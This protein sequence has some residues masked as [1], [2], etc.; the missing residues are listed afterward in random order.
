MEDIGSVHFRLQ[1]PE[2]RPI[3]YLLRADVKLQGS[4]IF[5]LLSE[6]SEGWPFT[7]EN[8]SDYSFT[9]YQTVRLP[10]LAQCVLAVDDVDRIRLVS[11][12]SLRP[13]LFRCIL[14]Q[15]NRKWTTHGIIRLLEGRK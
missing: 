12:S 14:F 10:L 2:G 3:M 11:T 8:D 7:I 5:I 1:G 9:F 6:S 13:N 15:K 4:T